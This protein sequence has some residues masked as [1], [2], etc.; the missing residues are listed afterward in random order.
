MEQALNEH[1]FSDPRWRVIAQG[2]QTEAWLNEGQAVGTGG[3]RMPQPC[4]LRTGH[5]HYRFASSGSPRASQLGGGWWLEFE[6]FHKIRAFAQEHGYSVSEAARLM[7]ALPFAWTRVDLL[8]RAL[9]VRPLKAYAGEGKPAQGATAGS[10]KGTVWIPTQ[11]IRVRQL[12]IP[13]LTE[14]GLPPAEQLHE[15][16]FT[17][18]EIMRL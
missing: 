4:R 3:I 16:A 14:R 15:R 10:D 8:V 2:F 12:Y 5:Y 11:H 9:L 13:G 6:E 7:L 17:G 1:C 18:A